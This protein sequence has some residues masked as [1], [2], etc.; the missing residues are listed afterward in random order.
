MGSPTLQ[1][2]NDPISLTLAFEAAAFQTRAGDG[3][4]ANKWREIA[5]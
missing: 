5:N 1:T 2:L 3:R 4:W